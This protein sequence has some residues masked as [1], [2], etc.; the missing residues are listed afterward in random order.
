MNLDQMTHLPTKLPINLA[1]IDELLSLARVSTADPGA[2]RWLG[3]AL[4]A[5]RAIAAIEPQPCPAEHNAPLDKIERAAHALNLALT[6]LRRHSHPHRNFW[7]FSTFGP[8]RADKVENVDFNPTLM[9]IRR[10]AH[11]A[12][13]RRI[14]RLPDRRKQH[15]VGLALA[16]CARFSAAK[17]SSDVNNFFPLFAERFFEYATGLS[18]D[19]KGEGIDRQIRAAM[20]KLPI[21]MQRVKHLN[22]TRQNRPDFRS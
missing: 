3:D 14:G 19:E 20:K 22:E 9:T 6:E 16:F 4:A 18:V 5:A 10:A 12:R 8:A 15:I 7:R 1:I 11:N 21:Q 13:V 17:P 2:R